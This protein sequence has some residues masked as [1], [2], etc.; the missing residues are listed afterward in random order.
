MSGNSYQRGFAYALKL[1][2]IRLRSRSELEKRFKEKGYQK[3]IIKKV[4]FSLKDLEYIN[5]LKFAKSWVEDRMRFN[6]KA[7]RVLR[8]ELKD[9]GVDEKI[10][11]NVISSVENNYNFKDVASNLAKKR[12]R[13]FKK[14]I[15]LDKAKKRI[16]DY[17]RRRGFTYNLVYEIINREFKKDEDR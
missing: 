16:F 6:P 14:G 7:P 4:I 8:L 15:E 2:N 9:K 17:L 3:D 11:N 1:L 10:I 13:L 12:I 5:D